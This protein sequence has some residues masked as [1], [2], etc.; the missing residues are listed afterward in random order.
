MKKVNSELE[1]RI[2]ELEQ[3]KKHLLK[4]VSHDVKSPFNKLFALSNLLQMTSNN[5]NEEQ[6]DYLNRMDWVIKEG[7][8]V[9]RNLMDLRAIDQNNIELSLEQ[10]NFNSIVS[11]NIKNYSKQT[12]VKNININENLTKVTIWSDK[13]LLERIIDQL[14]SNSIK[15]TPINY[16][17]QLNLTQESNNIVFS[18]KSESGPL[19]PEEITKLFHKNTS[20]SIRPTHGESALG[21]GLYIAQAYANKLGGIIEAN[22]E[23]KMVGFILTLPIK[24][25]VS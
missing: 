9:V 8:T 20:I 10:L 7:L 12:L 22:Q 2:N 18:I 25:A 15:F 11:D 14:I 21:N 16:S 24:E 17:V 5:L 4:L 3:E 13:K 1:K 6:L 23:E 19:D